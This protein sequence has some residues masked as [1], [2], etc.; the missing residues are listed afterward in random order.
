FCCISSHRFNASNTCSHSCFTYDLEITYP[1]GAGHMATATQFSR[2]RLIECDH[3]HTV[4]VFLTEQHTSTNCL[5]LMDG[6][7]AKLAAR[8]VFTD[9]LVDECFNFGK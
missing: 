7:I 8:Y 1:T 2:P 4:T 3:P 5:R 9:A 6:K